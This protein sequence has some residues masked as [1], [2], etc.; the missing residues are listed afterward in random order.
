MF[1]K[2]KSIRLLE[3]IVIVIYVDMSG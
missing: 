2:A 1:I 3:Y